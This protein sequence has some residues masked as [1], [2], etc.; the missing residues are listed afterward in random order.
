M[1]PIPWK[2]AAGTKTTSPGST[3]RHETC[4]TIEPSSTTPRNCRGSEPLLQVDKVVMATIG[5][6]WDVAF[7]QA[8][9]N[10][11]AVAFAQSKI[12]ADKARTS[13]PSRASLRGAGPYHPR[14]LVLESQ[15]DIK[16]NERFV[17]G[18]EVGRPASG[19]LLQKTGKLTLLAASQTRKLPTKITR[20]GG[21][22]F[23]VLRSPGAEWRGSAVAAGD[24]R[25]QSLRRFC[26][27]T[28]IGMSATRKPSRTPSSSSSKCR[29]RDH[30]GIASKNKH[31]PYKSG[32][33]DWLKVECA[34]WKEENK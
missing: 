23:I 21:G 17:L 8:S 34:Q 20:R 9:V 3:A 26:A 18:D 24:R 28:I 16:L 6:K 1:L 14:S 10:L 12:A 7:L 31:T 15:R 25:K 33:C 5:H 32:K 2:V 22:L 19:A 29:Q 27:D 30:E 13:A 4:C 11:G